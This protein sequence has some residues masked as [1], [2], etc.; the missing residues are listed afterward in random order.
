[1]YTITDDNEL[2]YNGRKVG[3]IT[4]RVLLEAMMS[5]HTRLL[6]DVIERYKIET[7]CQGMINQTAENNIRQIALLLERSPDRPL[8]SID[9]INAARQIALRFLRWKEDFMAGRLQP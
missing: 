6:Q 2:I 4:D 8:A 9:S 5:D 3:T 7:S 1:M